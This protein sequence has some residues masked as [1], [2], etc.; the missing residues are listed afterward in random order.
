MFWLFAMQGAAVATAA[1]AM[2]PR[3]ETGRAG[4]GTA[5]RQLGLIAAGVSAIGLADQAPAPFDPLPD[6]AHADEIKC[7]RNRGRIAI[8]KLGVEADL[9]RSPPRRGFTQG[10]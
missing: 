2:L 4:T 8:V 1:Y 3:G 7:Q 9:G 10:R 5:W 6:L